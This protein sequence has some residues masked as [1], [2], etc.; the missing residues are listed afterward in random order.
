MLKI[1]RKAKHISK[2]G[3]S[4]V[5]LIDARQMTSYLGLIDSTYTYAMYKK[6]IKPNINFK[7]MKNYISKC[8]RK[9]NKRSEIN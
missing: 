3:P 1:T 6:W 9:Q 4:F 8:Q 5:K 7:S 2:K